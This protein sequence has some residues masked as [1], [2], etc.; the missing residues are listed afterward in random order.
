MKVEFSTTD[1]GFKNY[2]P[3]EGTY[4]DSVRLF[5]SSRADRPCIW[6][7]VTDMNGTESMVHLTLEDATRLKDHLKHLTKNHYQEV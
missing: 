7:S 6:V 4:G 1:R 3:I 5:E 2:A